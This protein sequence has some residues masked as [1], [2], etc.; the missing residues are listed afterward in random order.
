MAI[1]TSIIQNQ[2]KFARGTNGGANTII[3]W[4]RAIKTLIS[5]CIFAS[6]TYLVIASTMLVKKIPS[7]TSLAKSQIVTYFTSTQT[8]LA[9]SVV[10]LSHCTLTRAAVIVVQRIASS[11][12]CAMRL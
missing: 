12:S 7:I 3:A 11:T 6:R 2:S 5:D 10:K 9:M 4:V 8:V 1:A